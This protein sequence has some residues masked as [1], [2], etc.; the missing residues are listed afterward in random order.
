VLV[1]FESNELEPKSIRISWL[2]P[3]AESKDI[4][5]KKANRAQKENSLFMILTQD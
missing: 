3:L 5:N 1:T 2:C 4:L